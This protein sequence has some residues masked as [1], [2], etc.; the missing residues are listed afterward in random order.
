MIVCLSWF[1]GLTRFVRK[2]RN[3]WNETFNVFDGRTGPSLVDEIGSEVDATK[4]A[5]QTN[6]IICHSNCA[7]W[8]RVAIV[9]RLSLGELTARS[10]LGCRLIL[11][12]RLLRD[13]TVSMVGVAAS[14]AGRPSWDL[15]RR[16]DDAPS[17]F[18]R[19]AKRCETRIT[20]SRRRRRRRRNGSRE[21]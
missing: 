16:G 14:P 1:N 12:Q 4:T 2:S 20:V 9:W 18:Q 6:N 7:T 17:I 21:L 10:V 3:R 5:L 13:A 11:H 19:L 15:F 8:L